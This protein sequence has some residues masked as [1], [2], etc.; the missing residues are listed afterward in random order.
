MFRAC[1]TWTAACLL[2]AA[3][4]AESGHSDPFAEFGW[5]YEEN[6]IE[7]DFTNA[8]GQDQPLG[9]CGPEN[10][11]FA[12]EECE[13]R[14]QSPI[15][16]HEHVHV[17]HTLNS[18]KWRVSSDYLECQDASI[19]MNRYTYNISFSEESEACHEAYVLDFLEHEYTA[20][21][22]QI[23][24]PSEHT[25]DHEHFD[26]EVQ[27]VHESENGHFVIVSVLVEASD[28][29]SEN[30]FL[31]HILDAVERANL[32]IGGHSTQHF[33][34]NDLN[35]VDTF[36][37]SIGLQFNYY[38]Y[39]GSLTVPSC[40]SATWAILSQPAYATPKQI[41]QFKAAFVNAS[42][43]AWSSHGENVRPL[44]K[45]NVFN[46]LEFFVDEFCY[47]RYCHN[48]FSIG[49]ELDVAMAM[50]FLALLILF[51]VIFEFLTGKL[52][53]R[54]RDFHTT[55]AMVSHVY[56]E[57]SILGVV[58]FIAVCI[59]KSCSF[60]IP[61]NVMIA[62]EAMHIFIFS[63]GVAFVLF[64]GISLHFTYNLSKHW[65]KLLTIAENIPVEVAK[66]HRFHLFGHK[67]VGQ[68]LHVIDLG[69]CFM[70]GKFVQI[71]NLPHTFDFQKYIMLFLAQTVAHMLDIDVLVWVLSFAYLLMTISFMFVFTPQPGF[72]LAGLVHLVVICLGI[73]LSYLSFK[74]VLNI[75]EIDSFEKLRAKAK[76][77]EQSSTRSHLEAEEMAKIH[78]S[79][80][81]QFQKTRNSAPRFSLTRKSKTTDPG[82]ALISPR[83]R[84][85]SMTHDDRVLM[86]ARMSKA[87][88]PF[89]SPVVINIIFKTCT[90]CI[91]F[92]SCLYALVVY[93]YMDWFGHVIIVLII[94]IGVCSLIPRFIVMKTLVK[95]FAKLDHELVGKVL[96]YATEKRAMQKELADF[97]FPDFDLRLIEISNFKQVIQKTLFPKEKAGKANPT[98]DEDDDKTVDPKRLVERLQARNMNLSISKVHR[99]K[100]LL[101]KDRSGTVELSEVVA[102]M[103]DERVYRIDK[104]LLEGF[105]KHRDTDKITNMFKLRIKLGNIPD[106]LMD[107]YR[108]KVPAD[109][110]DK[111]LEY[112]ASELL[113]VLTDTAVTALAA[114]EKPE[115]GAG[116][117]AFEMRRG[118]G[119]DDATKAELLNEGPRAEQKVLEYLKA[120]PDSK[121][122]DFL[123]L[124]NWFCEYVNV[125]SEEVHQN[126]LS[127]SRDEQGLDEDD[128]DHQA[129]MEGR[130]LSS[131][132]Q[133]DDQDDGIE[134]ALNATATS[135][136][137]RQPSSVD[138][139]VIPQT[140]EPATFDHSLTPADFEGD[141]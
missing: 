66:T 47:E 31:A 96:D 71:F 100:R 72:I 7:A 67:C 76:G 81:E 77:A 86:H 51:T 141:K 79:S 133:H 82:H 3:V 26:L 139:L 27:F 110:N 25:I 69:M 99:F 30:Q 94:T 62:F 35:F 23:H 107:V 34:K 128:D 111:A 124:R 83:G 2:C 104:R 88:Q 119:V 64:S 42:E 70:R 43:S 22:F 8:C 129:L 109:A 33:R 36:L 37:P 75:A 32:T 61:E 59:I 17:S 127:S 19:E 57:L 140:G 10:W 40:A 117:K 16:I 132:P 122:I 20:K 91:S 80:L 74:K 137:T 113:K 52:D 97:L 138:I 29:F 112:L 118:L 13:A 116:E 50:A 18:L 60:D 12:F 78:Y 48:L 135:I 14:D 65:D 4:T 131:I 5:S 134:L 58:S 123:T 105:Q 108:G 102:L 84:Q 98:E 68:P 120:D 125:R 24:H 92:Y 55:A 44:Q 15:D 39:H 87:W 90:L 73:F 126:E 114:D 11:K 21:H 53:E 136:P 101:D 106:V 41:E 89:G 130:R 38:S 45:P 49:K 103:E 54:V 93:V 56:K 6:P 63:S 85:G 115:S 1:W 9:D 46:E 28:E 121:S 95:C